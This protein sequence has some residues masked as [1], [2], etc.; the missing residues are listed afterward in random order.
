MDHVCPQLAMTLVC[1]SKLRRD[2]WTKQ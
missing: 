2:S 1:F